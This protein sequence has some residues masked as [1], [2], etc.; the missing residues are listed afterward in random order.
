MVNQM[1]VVQRSGLR[2]PSKL[3]CKNKRFEVGN[4]SSRASTS[5]QGNV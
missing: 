4:E 2:F 1:F 3:C 5:Y